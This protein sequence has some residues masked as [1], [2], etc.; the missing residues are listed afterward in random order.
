MR[1]NSISK[2]AS[3][4]YGVKNCS[5]AI[6]KGEANRKSPRFSVVCFWYIIRLNSQGVKEKRFLYAS[7]VL[8]HTYVHEFRH[9][10]DGDGASGRV[11]SMMS[12]EACLV[13]GSPHPSLSFVARANQCEREKGMTNCFYPMRAL[14]GGGFVQELAMLCSYPLPR[15]EK[16][17]SLTCCFS[18]KARYGEA[19]WRE[20]VRKREGA[21]YSHSACLFFLSRVHPLSLF[22]PCEFAP[23]PGSKVGLS[24]ELS[25]AVTAVISLLLPPPLCRFGQIPLSLHCAHFSASAAFDLFFLVVVVVI[26]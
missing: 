8:S 13:V 17:L 16:M 11:V 12:E 2:P 20:R 21:L 10:N 3:V 22:L 14:S 19:G 15:W 4:K 9:A 25:Y 24:S 5:E 1:C 18:Y 6:A 26:I 23:G 7:L